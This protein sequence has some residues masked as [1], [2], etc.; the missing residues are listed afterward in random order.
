TALAGAEAARSPRTPVTSLVTDP[1]PARPVEDVTLEELRQFL[2]HPV[3]AF[4][5][6]R[7]DVS[8]P[9]EAEETHD[10]IPITLD[11]LDKWKVG[12][13]LLTAVLRGAEPRTSLR[14]ERMRG[15]LPPG[16]LGDRTL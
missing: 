11:G 9:L 1:L 2:I 10:D 16:E 12:E 5:R 3:R 8:S 4:L 14:A 15:L 7:L 6:S 13:R